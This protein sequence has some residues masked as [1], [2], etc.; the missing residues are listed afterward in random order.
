MCGSVSGDVL[1]RIILLGG[2]SIY[3]KADAYYGVT[4]RLDRAIY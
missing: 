1:V 2:W 4:G 3:D